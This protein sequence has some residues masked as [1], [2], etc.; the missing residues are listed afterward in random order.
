MEDAVIGKVVVADEGK[1]ETMKVVMRKMVGIVVIVV[2]IVVA[3]VAIVVAIVAM[4]ILILTRGVVVGK[5]K[6]VVRVIERRIDEDKGQ[7]RDLD[8][9]QDLDHVRGRG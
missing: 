3:I 7:G 6:D 2:V 1:R 4:V 9:D 5:D 8:Q